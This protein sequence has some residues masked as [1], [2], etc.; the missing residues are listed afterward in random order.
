MEKN[1]K[2]G[3]KVNTT[4]WL[5]NVIV[6]FKYSLKYDNI[7]LELYNIYPIKTSIIK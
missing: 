7:E 4:S 6:L 2:V 3:Y 1:K 5:I